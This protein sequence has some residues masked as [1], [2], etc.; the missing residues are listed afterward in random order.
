MPDSQ[1]LDFENW[2]RDANVTL[3]LGRLSSAI[4]DNP[5][6]SISA[7]FFFQ[8]GTSFFQPNSL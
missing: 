8:I 2:D 1:D 4:Q 5:N 3:D 7:T 6:I